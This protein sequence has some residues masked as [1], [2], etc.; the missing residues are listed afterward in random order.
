MTVWERRQ[1]GVLAAR[2]VAL[3]GLGMVC[4]VAIDGA[5]GGDAPFTRARELTAEI[6]LFS[7][8]LGTAQWAAALHRDATWLAHRAAGGHPMRLAVP[9]GT[10]TALIGAAWLG[11]VRLSPEP[12]HGGPARG[13]VERLESGAVVLWWRD[14]PE[15]RARGRVASGD[16]AGAQLRRTSASPGRALADL[17]GTPPRGDGWGAVLVTSVLAAAALALHPLRGRARGVAGENRGE[18]S[19]LG[20]GLVFGFA[21]LG[22]EVVAGVLQAAE[23][24]LPGGLG[25]VGA[26]AWTRVGAAARARVRANPWSAHGGRGRS[27]RGCV[28][29]D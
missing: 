25:F 20:F 29:S 6:L 5:V 2:V 1:V 21:V 24:V 28:A 13:W 8:I 11:V 7:G 10:I 16:A 12:V 3:V 15:K 27:E 14:G 18:A 23:W 9:V 22:L 4:T 26:L 17:R 19:A